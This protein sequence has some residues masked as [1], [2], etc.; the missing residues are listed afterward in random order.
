MAFNQNILNEDFQSDILRKILNTDSAKEYPRQSSWFRKEELLNT[1]N[2]LKKIENKPN[3]SDRVI[4]GNLNLAAITDDDFTKETW[5]EGIKNIKK[6]L[7]A[8]SRGYG[9]SI[10]AFWFTSDDELIASSVNDVIASYF[11]PKEVMSL[12]YFDGFDFDNAPEDNQY[13]EFKN[14]KDT[15][16]Y[17]YYFDR[18]KSTRKLSEKNLLYYL[19]EQYDNP[20]NYVYIIYNSDNIQRHPIKNYRSNNKIL[21]SSNPKQRDSDFKNIRMQNQNLRELTINKNNAKKFKDDISEDI[22][23]MIKDFREFIKSL[24]LEKINDLLMLEITQLIT[25]F[26]SAL[27]HYYNIYEYNQE[28][29]NITRIYSSYFNPSSDVLKARDLNLDKAKSS[30]HLFKDRLK[31]IQKIING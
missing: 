16:K 2:S 24:K 26:N 7:K 6:A 28:I 9:G 25:Y 8:G 15:K 1:Y 31:T 11:T 22:D 20:R 17:Q 18:N 21:Y 5:K 30:I 14:N 19:G 12:Q 3:V 4:L 29:L 23:L 10:Y 13:I 27:S